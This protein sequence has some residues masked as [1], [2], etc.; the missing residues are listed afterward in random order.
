MK[1]NN[2]GYL[3]L[4]AVLTIIA[5]LSVFSLAEFEGAEENRNAFL[6]VSA[7]PAATTTYQYP[8]EIMSLASNEL[9]ASTTL[10]TSRWNAKFLR[11]YHPENLL[12]F[13][14]MG[15]NDQFE[16][17]F[18]WQ[19]NASE[20]KSFN[21]SVCENCSFLNAFVLSKEGE[22]IFMLKSGKGTPE[23]FKID[24]K[25]YSF[26]KEKT[27][28]LS[29][30]D[31][32]YIRTQGMP[33]GSA[34][35]QDTF[36]GIYAKNNKATYGY[37]WNI[38]LAWSFDD[39]NVPAPRERI[40]QVINN[41]YM[42][43]YTSPKLQK[44]NEQQPFIELKVHNKKTAEWSSISIDG[45][46]PNMREFGPWIASEQRMQV[47]NT[48]VTPKKFVGDNK[49]LTADAR[50]YVGRYKQSGKMTL[51]NPIENRTIKIDTKQPDSEI[52][53]VDNEKVYYRVNDE[54]YSAD[55]GQ[56]SLENIKLMVK[57]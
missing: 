12:I 40:S 8:V 17:E 18:S 4:L 38:D 56:S 5:F 10:A 41:E 25:G 44:T 37:T 32:Q 54:L 27:V 1:K 51:I 35:S 52:L 43:I 53:L 36:S 46:L 7:T 14:R 6:L 24:V 26:S 9:S 22:L 23:D 42:R 50:A 57:D 49:F 3:I 47:D 33:G 16:G 28:D 29:L 31:L 21:L 11:V 45:Q 34:S 30:A 55:I 15:K 48:H 19:R 13:G 2:I 20:L 39:G